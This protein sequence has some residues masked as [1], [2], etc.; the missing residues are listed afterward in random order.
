[1]VFGLLSRSKSSLMVRSSVPWWLVVVAAPTLFAGPF[2]LVS[3]ISLL[4]HHRKATTYRRRHI[5]TQRLFAIDRVG[6]SGQIQGLVTAGGVLMD[7]FA[8]V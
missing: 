6:K 8:A 4:R 7:H 3:L 1:M 5:Y 2:I